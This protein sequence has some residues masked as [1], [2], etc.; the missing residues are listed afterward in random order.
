MV[1]MYI[2][3]ICYAYL[4]PVTENCNAV[5][6]TTAQCAHNITATLSDLYCLSCDA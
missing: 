1:R 6:G 5:L 4:L 3:N 2:W